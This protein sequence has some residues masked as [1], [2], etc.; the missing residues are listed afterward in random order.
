M[1][2]NEASLS[3]KSQYSGCLLGGAVGDALGAPIEFMSWQAIQSKFGAEGL[4]DY[5]PAYGRIGAIT[6][7]TQMTLFTAEGLLRAMARQESKGICD[8]PSV[9]SHAYI[10]W[11][12]TQGEEN[13]RVSADLDGCLYTIPELHSRRAPGNTCISAMKDMGAFGEPAVNNSKG[14][15]GVMRV[16]PVALIADAC[17]GGNKV[18][19]AFKK[20]CDICA[21]TH[22]H[23][24]GQLSGGFL[25]AFLTALLAGESTEHAADTATRILTQHPEHEETLAAVTMAITLASTE[26]K[27]REALFSLGEGWVAEEALAMGLYC[28]LS[29]SS[30]QEA[31]LLAVNHG[32]DSDS[33]GA[34]A[35]SIS[36]LIS[37]DASI[38]PKWVS[39][40]EASSQI[41]EIAKD[42]FQADDLPLQIRKYP[43]S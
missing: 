33:T 19:W 6:D 41:V 42:L 28:A 12:H 9:V 38:P 5:S 24:T 10:R 32:G 27:S 8:I 16:A 36:G 34:I 1:P 15:G 37:G 4:T 20:A 2:D 21:I 13:K 25:A 14:C 30:F 39:Q 11:L 26:P 43:P 40:L 17:V 22:G 7:D 3:R 31:V 23:P 35:G 18:N 29:T